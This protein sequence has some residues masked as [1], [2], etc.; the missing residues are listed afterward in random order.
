[1]LLIA[2]GLTRREFVDPASRLVEHIRAAGEAGADGPPRVPV[3]WRPWFPTVTTVFRENS[4]LVTFLQELPI[5]SDLP[6]SVL[7]PRSARSRR[8]SIAG[9]TNTAPQVRLALY[10]LFL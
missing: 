5:A 9:S 4:D 7:P 6:A 8:L 2:G 3:A 1:M 10:H